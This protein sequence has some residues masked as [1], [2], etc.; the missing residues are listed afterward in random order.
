M[1]G[2]YLG[3]VSAQGSPR[4]HLYAPDRLEVPRGLRQRR[5]GR[6]LPRILRTPTRNFSKIRKN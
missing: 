6:R 1:H 3:E 2:V 4:A 5:V